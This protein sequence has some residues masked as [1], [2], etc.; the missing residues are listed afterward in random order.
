MK[1]T[2]KREFTRIQDSSIQGY[3][4]QISSTK[5]LQSRQE[6]QGRQVRENATGTRPCP[7][8]NRTTA[9]IFVQEVTATFRARRHG[10]YRLPSRT[11]SSSRRGKRGSSLQS[12]DN[13][14][15]AVTGVCGVLAA[16]VSCRYELGSQYSRWEFVT[17]SGERV[18]SS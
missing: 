6:C 5:Q 12:I 8:E 13:S 16:S 7:S 1:G 2:T 4:V 17:S 14:W 3:T 9:V 11:G 15:E 10:L 18:S